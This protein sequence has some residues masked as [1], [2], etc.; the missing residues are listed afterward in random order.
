MGL[1]LNLMVPNADDSTDEKGTSHALISGVA[2]GGYAR[3]VTNS[4]CLLCVRERVK[5]R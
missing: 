2:F 3:K 1:L 4:V 5:I